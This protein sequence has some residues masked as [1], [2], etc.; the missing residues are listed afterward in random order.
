M[1]NLTALAEQ[2]ET[3]RCADC[4]KFIAHADI[5]AGLCSHHFV[6]DNAFGREI[7][8]WTCAA[9]LRAIARSKSDDR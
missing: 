8:E 9:C 1:T 7:S 2:V 3:I 4:G 5:K 6:P